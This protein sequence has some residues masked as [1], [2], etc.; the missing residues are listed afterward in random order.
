MLDAQAEG[1][2]DCTFQRQAEVTITEMNSCLMQ[3]LYCA[4]AAD[5][6]L[7]VIIAHQ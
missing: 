2:E 5:L 3:W 4:D 7:K 6:Y 1:A